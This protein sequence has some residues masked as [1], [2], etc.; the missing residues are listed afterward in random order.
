VRNIR[1]THPVDNRTDICCLAGLAGARRAGWPAVVGTAVALTGLLM[2]L[3]ILALPSAAMAR[4]PCPVRI[5][6]SAWD[7]FRDLAVQLQAGQKPPLEAYD[8]LRRHPAYLKMQEVVGRAKLNKYVLR[9]AMQAVFGDSGRALTD[10]SLGSG[11]SLEGT[12]FY[13]SGHLGSVDS[14]MA[15]ISGSGEICR[16]IDLLR[17]YLP[18]TEMPDTLRLEFL[19]MRPEVHL[20]GDQVYV[21]AGLSLAAGLG[22]LSRILAS[23]IYRHQVGA[24][25]PS[26]EDL[27]GE[28]AVAG[29]FQ[30]LSIEG[31]A[32]WLEDYPNLVFASGHPFLGRTDSRRNNPLQRATTTLTAMERFLTIL[33]EHP[34]ELVKK[35]RVVHDLL[36]GNS[37]YSPLGYSMALL[38]VARFGEERLQEV[39]GS[40]SAFLAAYQEAALMNRQPSAPA[41]P[42]QFDPE[43]AG[44]PALDPENFTQVMAWLKSSLAG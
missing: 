30:K 1:Q 26:P 32:T 14:L 33:R 20:I 22:Q 3:L 44:L 11:F 39:A 8:Q 17:P 15:R 9:E 42:A 12:C 19:A 29:A 34:E 6:H 37:A 28:K 43:L 38:I 25:L 40:P 10:S 16:T 41:L 35:G 24:D 21:D 36:L 4:N 5:D 13:L 7:G 18:A 27:E 23:L 2:G 31:I